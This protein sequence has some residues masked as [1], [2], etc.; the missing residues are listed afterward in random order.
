MQK[1]KQKGQADMNATATVSAAA[2]QKA[3]VPAAKL[4]TPRRA[5]P[6]NTWSMRVNVP[7]VRETMHT[8]TGALVRARTP[9]DVADHCEDLRQLAQEAFVVFDLTAKNT[10]IDKRLVSLGLLDSCQVH[11]REVFRGAIQNNAAAVVV[12][13]NHP[14]G[15]PTPSSED[16]RITRQLVEAGRILGIRVLDSVVIGRP[17][18]ANNNAGFLSLRESGLVSFSD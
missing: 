11:S 4:A 8:D 17:D 10:V 18:P 13:H 12:A 7:L 3:Q 1:T 2:D 6:E 14:S 16:I 5:R 9:Q 15:D